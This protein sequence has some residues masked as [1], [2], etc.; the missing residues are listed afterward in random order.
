M[1]SSMACRLLLITDKV[2]INNNYAQISMR[3]EM[4]QDNFCEQN[5]IKILKTALLKQDPPNHKIATP[6]SSSKQN[7]D[8]IQTSLFLF[9]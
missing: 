8:E 3:A 7:D 9:I 1:T 6:L 5:I 2:S 4:T